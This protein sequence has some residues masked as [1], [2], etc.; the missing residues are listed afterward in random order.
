MA[1]NG[2]NTCRIRSKMLTDTQISHFY[3]HGFILMKNPF[4]EAYMQ[5]IDQADSSNRKKTIGQMISTNSPASFSPLV[6]WF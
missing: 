3:T 4:G 1:Y 6:S 2:S 5:Q